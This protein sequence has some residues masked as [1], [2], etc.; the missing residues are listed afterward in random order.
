MN[1]WL[2]TIGEELPIVGDIRKVR[3]AL[4]ADKLVE[5]GHHVLWW[6]SAFDHFRKDW[7]FKKDREWKVSEHY[8]IKALKGIGYKKNVCLSRF[9]DHR[10]IAKKFRRQS[11]HVPIPDI[12]VASTPSYDLAYEAALYAGRSSIPLLVDIRD[13][14][15]DIFFD[16]IP[17]KLQAIFRILF[18]REFFMFKKTMKLADGIIAV[19]NSYLTLGLT[20]GEREKRA[21]DRVFYLGY[22][23]EGDVAPVTEKILQFK[24]YLEGKF[25]ITFIGTFAHYHD[26]SILVECA[27]RLVNEKI[28]F[29][30]AGDGEFMKEIQDKARHL[31]NIT[32]P[33]WLN[34]KDIKALLRHSHVGVCTTPRMAEFF[35][36]KTFL[37]LSAGLPVI[38]AFQGDLHEFI[39]QHRIGLNYFPNDVEMLTACIKKLNN[40]QNLYKEMS[41]NVRTVFDKWL[42]ADTI[43]SQYVEHIENVYNSRQT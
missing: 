1:V 9:I 32:L 39:D 37:Y 3:T 17:K 29:V 42:D 40:D 2:I 28:H 19:M 20:Y 5:R 25:V 13:K 34:Q 11:S 21:T 38:S 30:I 18:Y 23:R 24:D 41:G 36:N 15:P 16:F 14:W 26:P 4:L 27:K 33:G 35:P 7:V 43:Y 8:T 6:T 31:P 22:G 10:I 12:I